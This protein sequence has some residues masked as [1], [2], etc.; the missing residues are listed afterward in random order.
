MGG[1]G[2]AKI[3]WNTL[4]LRGIQNIRFIIRMLHGYCV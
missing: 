4:L 1:S 3:A 2:F